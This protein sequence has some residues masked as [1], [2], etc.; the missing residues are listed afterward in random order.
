MEIGWYAAIIRVKIKR[1]LHVRVG[2]NLTL[3]IQGRVLLLPP[4]LSTPDEARSG[5]ALHLILPRTVMQPVNKIYSFYYDSCR[6]NLLSVRKVHWYACICVYACMHLCSRASGPE[7][8]PRILM[9]A[10]MHVWMYGC[11][12]RVAGQWG[13]EFGWWGDG[14]GMQSG[15]GLVGDGVNRSR[16]ED[17]AGSWCINRMSNNSVFKILPP[18]LW[19][20]T[21]S[22]SQ[23]GNKV[24]LVWQIRS[25]GKGFFLSAYF[26][27][28]VCCTYSVTGFLGLALCCEII[29]FEYK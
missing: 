20:S 10:I 16:V 4:L 29:Y 8:C 9:S 2:T 6:F 5:V 3:R 7:L 13:V 18:V 14:D 27:T 17:G 22:T 11:M 28:M 15:G 24:T 21:T 26:I 25:C 12:Q 23:V 19:G 1:L